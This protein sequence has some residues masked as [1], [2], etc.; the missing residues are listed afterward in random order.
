MVYWRQSQMFAL[1]KIISVIFSK[2]QHGRTWLF[3]QQGVSVFLIISILFKYVLKNDLLET[4]AHFKWCFCCNFR[5]NSPQQYQIQSSI[6]A[7]LFENSLAEPKLA[8]YYWWY[9]QTLVLDKWFRGKF[10]ISLECFLKITTISMGFSLK[11]IYEKRYL[12][13]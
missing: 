7:H 3:I 9:Q 4:C 13:T 10:A 8:V 12:L 5:G 6:I 1:C 2:A 11:W